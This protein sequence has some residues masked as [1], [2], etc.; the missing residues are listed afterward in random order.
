MKEGTLKQNSDR[1]GKKK[2]QFE[3]CSID[4]CPVLMAVPQRSGPWEAAE[5]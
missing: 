4:Q 3:Y 2:R 5:G 1:E